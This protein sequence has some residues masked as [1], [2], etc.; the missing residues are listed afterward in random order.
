M[1]FWASQEKAK[2]MIGASLWNSVNKFKKKNGIMFV[3]TFQMEMQWELCKKEKLRPR[4]NTFNS[5]VAT[6]LNNICSFSL[7]LEPRS[8]RC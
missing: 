1:L 5:P 7:N 2:Y 6:K 4:L 8:Q 3:K